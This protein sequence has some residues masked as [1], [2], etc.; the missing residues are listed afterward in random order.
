VVLQQA[1]LRGISLEQYPGVGRAFR[2]LPVSLRKY[3]WGQQQFPRAAK[4]ISRQA[5]LAEAIPLF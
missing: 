4:I 2:T 5:V 1:E 3:R